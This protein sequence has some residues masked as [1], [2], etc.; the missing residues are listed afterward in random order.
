M[1]NSTFQSILENP[2]PQLEEFCS[3]YFSSFDIYSIVPQD[4]GDFVIEV[5]STYGVNTRLFNPTFNPLV[6][7]LNL[8]ALDS[9]NTYLEGQLVNISVS[10][11]ASQRYYL[12][13]YS[14]S[15]YYYY[16]SGYRLTFR[17]SSQF[18]MNK[19]TGKYSCS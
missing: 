13:L 8:V 5:V 14:N 11:L 1:P 15:Y 19:T 10:L 4:A 7:A 16:S 18:T 9:S 3:S 2:L 12:V 6:S 17:G